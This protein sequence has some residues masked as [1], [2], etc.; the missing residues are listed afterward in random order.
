[1]V[2]L[3]KAVIARYKHGKHSFEVLVDPEKVDAIKRVAEIDIS[4]VL[5]AEDIFGDV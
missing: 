5:A 4:A 2:S 3:D 1:M